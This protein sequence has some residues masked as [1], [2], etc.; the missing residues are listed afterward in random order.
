V[1]RIQNGIRD[2]RAALQ[3]P[4]LECTRKPSLFIRGIHLHNSVDMNVL[5]KTG[6]LDDG[7]LMVVDASG[8]TNIG[9]EHHSFKMMARAYSLAKGTQ[10]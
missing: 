3:W 10:L 2:F 6:A 9:S 1:E 4:E 8:I 7:S 5:T